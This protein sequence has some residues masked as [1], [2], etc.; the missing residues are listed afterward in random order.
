MHQDTK[1][2]ITIQMTAH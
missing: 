1:Q 2:L